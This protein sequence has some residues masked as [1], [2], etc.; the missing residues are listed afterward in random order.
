[1]DIQSFHEEEKESQKNNKTERWDALWGYLAV[2]RLVCHA[3]D[4]FVKSD[5]DKLVKSLV[6]K[7]MN[8]EK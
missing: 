1:M 2:K 7:P 3:Q 5:T 4:I 6:Y 8:L